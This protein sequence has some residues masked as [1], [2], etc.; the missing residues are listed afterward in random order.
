MLTDGLRSSL[1]L[2]LRLGRRRRLC[3]CSYPTTLRQLRVSHRR[4]PRN[5]PDSASSPNLN[6][7]APSRD[8]ILHDTSC[9][10][11]ALP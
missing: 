4:A 8:R 2:R 1:R 9:R 6:T 3:P 7:K 10:G 11:P 5:A